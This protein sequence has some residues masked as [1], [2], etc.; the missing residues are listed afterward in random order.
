M[1]GRKYLIAYDTLKINNCEILDFD[2]S[3]SIYTI[4]PNGWKLNE[5]PFKIDTM[6]IKQKLTE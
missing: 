5:I 2:V 3:D 1:N 6:L 4:P